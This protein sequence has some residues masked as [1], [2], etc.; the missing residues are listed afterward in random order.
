MVC[1]HAPDHSDPSGDRQGEQERYISDIRVFAQFTP[2]P[3]APLRLELGA[4][5]GLMRDIGLVR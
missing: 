3:V 4:V 2:E 1:G 5:F